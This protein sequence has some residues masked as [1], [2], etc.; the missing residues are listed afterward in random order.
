C[1][2]ELVTASLS[3]LFSL[4]LMPALVAGLA[5]ATCLGV[6]W[7]FGVYP[8]LVRQA[9]WY[10]SSPLTWRAFLVPFSRHTSSP[11][12][13][14]PARVL[15]SESENIP[16]RRPTLGA[17]FYCQSGPKHPPSPDKEHHMSAANNIT[18]AAL[19]AAAQEA[20]HDE[21]PA[22]K[23]SEAELTA[24]AVAVAAE[25]TGA[26]PAGGVDAAPDASEAEHAEKTA[27][28]AAMEAYKTLLREFM[29]ALKKLPG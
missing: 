6:R 2:R 14:K 4:I 16:P 26:E 13:G 24:A 1:D 12:A 15:N 21:V 19:A 10:Y 7:V 3:V 23:E 11:V 22:H 27:D 25:D 17:D 29:R 8:Q 20:I 18:A 5:Y 9:Q 28:E